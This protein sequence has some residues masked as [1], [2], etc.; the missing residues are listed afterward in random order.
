MYV[1]ALLVK[2]VSGDM[3]D[4]DGR[5][6]WSHES[7]KSCDHHFGF[8]KATAPFRQSTAEGEWLQATGQLLTKMVPAKGETTELWVGCGFKMEKHPTYIKTKRRYCKNDD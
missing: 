7:V 4:S 5:V 6:G 3:T 2:A 8:G 1:D